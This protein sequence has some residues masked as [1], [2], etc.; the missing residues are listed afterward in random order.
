MRRILKG[1]LVALG[2]GAVLIVS[3]VL[4]GYLLPADYA[5]ATSREIDAPQP[6]LHGYF[7]SQRG[8]R[9]WWGPVIA[10]GVE[11]GYPAMDLADLPGPAE[12][13]DMRF[14]FG[15]GGT[16]ME[17]WTVLEDQPPER[18]VYDIDFQILHVTRTITLEPVDAD[19]TKVGWSEMLHTDNPLVRWMAW[20]QGDGITENFDLALAGLEKVAEE[21]VTDTAGA[22]HR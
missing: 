17:V 18:V 15:A 10:E 20:L 2:A 1:L 13:K 16:V 21:T 14:Q 4:C 5:Y 11:K 12:G 3:F 8:L 22:G 7:A 9:A 6:I 19:T